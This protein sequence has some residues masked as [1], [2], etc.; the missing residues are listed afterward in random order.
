MHVQRRYFDKVWLFQKTKKV[1]VIVSSKNINIRVDQKF[2]VSLKNIR[3][4]VSCMK[5]KKQTKRNQ[6]GYIANDICSS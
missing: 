2:K 6:F 1:V 3:D 5:T 4:N